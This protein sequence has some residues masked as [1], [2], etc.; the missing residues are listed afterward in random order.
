MKT[1]PQAH[2]PGINPKEILYKELVERFPPP[3]TKVMAM[4]FFRKLEKEKRTYYSIDASIK[5]KKGV[6]SLKVVLKTKSAEENP[7]KFETRVDLF[8][9]DQKEYDRQ[10]IATAMEVYEQWLRHEKLKF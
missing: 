4:D 7:V 5:L 3:T 1:E 10:F 2:L 6:D 9:N 8:L